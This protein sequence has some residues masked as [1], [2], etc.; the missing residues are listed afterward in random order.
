MA[1]SVHSC[2]ARCIA[3]A[4]WWG[5]VLNTTALRLGLPK[6]K[7]RKMVLLVFSPTWDWGNRRIGRRDTQTMKGNGTFWSNVAPALR[8]ELASLDTAL[9]GDQESETGR[10][11]RRSLDRRAVHKERR[12]V[13]AKAL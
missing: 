13:N 1:R 11:P 2:T 6:E 8:T 9:G 3:V 7:L 10:M 5:Y 4:T 12:L